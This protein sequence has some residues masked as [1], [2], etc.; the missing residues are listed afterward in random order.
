MSIQTTLET[1]DLGQVFLVSSVVA[2]L[3]LSLVWIGMGIVSSHVQGPKS[4][5][6]Y[7]VNNILCEVW[8]PLRFDS[9]SVRRYE[10]M[11]D[12]EISL[13]P[14]Q[15]LRLLTRLHQLYGGNTICDA[16][17]PHACVFLAVFQ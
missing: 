11:D 8:R 13:D 2:F 3:C 7:R 4:L 1:F 5:R 16:Q 14:L 9:M 17:T 10:V 6:Q 15:L 12:S